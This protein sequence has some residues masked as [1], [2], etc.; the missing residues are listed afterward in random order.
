MVKR[1]LAVLLFL[2]HG[3]EPREH[4]LRCGG[5]VQINDERILYFYWWISGIQGKPSFADSRCQLRHN[6]AVFNN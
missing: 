4:S 3:N 5:T 2:S 1:H 6:R